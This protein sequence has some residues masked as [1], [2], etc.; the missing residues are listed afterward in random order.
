MKMN[1][2]SIYLKV[3]S[4]KYS[5]FTRSLANSS[6]AFLRESEEQCQALLSLSPPALGGVQHANQAERQENEARLP[7]P[8]VLSL[9]RGRWLARGRMIAKDGS[10]HQERNTQQYLLSKRIFY[11][12]KLARCGLFGQLQSML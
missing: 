10:H 1:S 5:V 11:C 3:S 12:S 8:S 4:R 2:Q 7:L 9:G 6:N